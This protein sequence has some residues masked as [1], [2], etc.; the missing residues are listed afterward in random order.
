MQLLPHNENTLNEINSFLIENK[1]CCVVNACGSGK[2]SIMSEF[3]K[4]NPK[5]TF[6]ILTKQ[7]NAKK[8]YTTFDKAFTRK[9]VHIFTY[10]KMHNDV[11]NEHF[12]PYKADYYLVDEAHYVGATLWSQDF[13]KITNLWKPR[14]IGFTATP[15]RYEDQGTDTTIV[16]KYFDSNTAG[17]YTAAELEKTGVFVQPD[18]VLSIYNMDKIIFT[19]KEKI[20]QSFLDN[21]QKIYLTKKL[22]TVENE[23]ETNGKPSLILKKYLPKY[24]YKKS[25]NKI[26]VYVPD[27][28]S[29]KEKETDITEWI[30]NAFPD[31]KI[32]S[33][34]YTYKSS[35][36]ELTSFMEEDDNYIKIL[37]SIDKIMETIHIEDLRITIM[38][39]RSI[40]NRIITQQFGRI[41]N[42]KNKNTPLIIDMVDNLSQLKTGIAY[43]DHN[44][45]S[46]TDQSQPQIYLPH[47]YW[48]Q[49]IFEQIDYT[50]KHANTFTYKGFTGNLS[51]ICYVYS[52]SIDHVKLL[53][54]TE[55]IDN[56]MQKARTV[57]RNLN[58]EIF[59][60]YKNISVPQLTQEQKEYAD[61]NIS[62]LF[63]YYKNKNITDEDIRQ[64]LVFTY[65]AEVQK[66][67]KYVDKK[68]EFNM[69]IR[70][71][72]HRTYLTML[73]NKEYHNEIFDANINAYAIYNAQ[74]MRSITINT[75]S[76]NIKSILL[77]DKINLSER[78]KKVL[79]YRFGLINGTEYTLEEVGNEMGVSRERIR[80]I[81]AKAMRKLRHPNRANQFIKRTNLFPPEFTPEFTY[82]L[83]R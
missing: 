83:Q 78:E 45:N 23:W 28:A 36:S 60:D 81:E 1:N 22:D 43:D 34:I 76:E 63:N 54:E 13:I 41:N 73:K 4:Q 82:Y 30:K 64:N 25:C 9:N 15:Q 29:M 75:S 17:N 51:E 72:L 40:S 50:I 48:A 70:Q 19:Q 49:N 18:Y 35:E 10:N 59:D 3:I 56:A 7:K 39:R 46:Y 61:K 71:K 67:W 62:L 37:F 52:K 58:Q 8:Y 38:L 79:L 12:T 26:L 69:R 55:T 21:K 53:L 14:L 20:G 2:T 31:K 32:Q 57:K 66:N 80:Q 27:M 44:R 6:V 68:H 24:M 42:L 74:R 65:Y 5:K 16:T 11:K 47:I 77:R 33:Y